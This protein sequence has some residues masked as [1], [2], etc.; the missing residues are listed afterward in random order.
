MELTL[1]TVGRPSGLLAD[2]IAE[3]EARAGRYWRLDVVEVAPEKASKNR[4]VSDIRMA[5]GERILAAV[6]AAAELVALTRTGTAWSSTDL[7]R[8]INDLAVAGAAGAAFVIGGA[9]G[10]DRQ[11]LRDAR[12]QLSLSPMTLPHDLARL[13][14]AEQIYRAGTIVRGE[15]YHK[16]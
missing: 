14:L 15:P 3:F 4:P 9:Y 6:P 13:M 12:R 10:L 16:G 1:I 7:A 8:Y 2:G 5:E 11:L